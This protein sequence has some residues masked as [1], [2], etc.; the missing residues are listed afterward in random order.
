MNVFN[1][2]RFMCGVFSCGV[3]RFPGGVEDCCHCVVVDRV[4][5]GAAVPQP[6]GQ[7]AADVAE[8]FQLAQHL[9]ESGGVDSLASFVDRVHNLPV[10]HRLAPGGEDSQALLAAGKLPEA[11]D[12]V[13]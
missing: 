3:E 12:P 2:N 1:A 9:P 11:G 5:H 8:G 7:V 10:E 6:L 4:A 13:V